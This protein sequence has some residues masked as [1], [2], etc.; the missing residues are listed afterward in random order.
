MLAI[1]AARGAQPARL[2][3]TSS[4]ITY[5]TPQ[6]TSTISTWRATPRHDRPLGEL[7][8]PGRRRRPAATT[9]MAS[10]AHAAAAPDADEPRDDRQDRAEQ[11]AHAATAPAAHIGR[12]QVVGVDA[13]LGAGVHGQRRLRLPHHVGGGCCGAVRRHAVAS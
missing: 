6:A 13:E 7:R 1:D 8:R 2:T 10:D 4:P 9:P 3:P 11:E 12:G 5:V